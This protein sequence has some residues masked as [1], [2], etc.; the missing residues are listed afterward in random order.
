MKF[1]RLEKQTANIFMSNTKDFRGTESVRMLAF[2]D[3]RNGNGA[4]DFL[5]KSLIV[6]TPYKI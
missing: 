6:I 1:I 3:C 5:R 2:Q 4:R